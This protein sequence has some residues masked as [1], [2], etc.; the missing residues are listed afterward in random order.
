MQ[1]TFLMLSQKNNHGSVLSKNISFFNSKIVSKPDHTDGLTQVFQETKD[2]TIVQLEEMLT[3]E[4]QLLMLII[5]AAFMLE[6]KFLELMQ[7]YF[8]D[9]GNSKL[10]PA[11]ESSKVIIYGLQDIFYKD[12]L[13][14]TIYQLALSQKFSVTGTDLDATPTFQQK[15]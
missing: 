12:V 9:N 14:N 7:K 11:S 2:L 5:N 10:D 13:K 4:E 3:L 1:K 15:K 8:L 6:L